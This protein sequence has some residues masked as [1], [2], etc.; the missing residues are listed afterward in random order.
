MIS[1]GWWSRWRKRRS[2]EPAPSLTEVDLP[3]LGPTPIAQSVDCLGAMCPRP[4]LLTMKVLGHMRIGEVIEVRCDSALPSRAS[5]RWRCRCT[6][7]LASVREAGGWRVY[8]RKG[9]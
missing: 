8:L 7:H 1:P 4:Q 2:D 3:G 5:R 9:Q 6:A